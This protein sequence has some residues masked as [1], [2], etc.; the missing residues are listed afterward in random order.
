[1]TVLAMNGLFGIPIASQQKGKVE[2]DDWHDGVE[3]AHP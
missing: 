3:T 2:L 1:M